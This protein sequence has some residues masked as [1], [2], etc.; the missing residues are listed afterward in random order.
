[1]VPY[2]ASSPT[3][4]AGQASPG[5]PNRRLFTSNV[6]RGDVHRPPPL[7]PDG[8]GLDDRLFP[9]SLLLLLLLSE[10]ELLLLSECDDVSL[11]FLDELSSLGRLPPSSELRP[12]NKCQPPDRLGWSVCVPASPD[13]VV[14]VDDCPPS[15]RRCGRP[16]LFPM[17]G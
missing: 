1:M 3:H 9:E 14:V 13:G 4:R 17:A 15:S 2:A 5:R 12:P 16:S 8:A 11:D 10:F 6:Y 7:P